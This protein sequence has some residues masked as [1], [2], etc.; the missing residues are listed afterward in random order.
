[1]GAPGE[2][3]AGDKKGQG[4]GGILHLLHTGLEGD[5]RPSRGP[6]PGLRGHG[7]HPLARPGAEGTR[8]PPPGPS[9]GLRGHGGHP[10]ARPRG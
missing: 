1:M 2:T 7:G 4:D 8:G 6:S 10:L 9:P 3:G 5:R